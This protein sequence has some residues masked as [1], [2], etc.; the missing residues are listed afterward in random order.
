MPLPGLP[1]D[2]TRAGKELGS[3]TA[4]AVPANSGSA[5]RVDEADSTCV[6]LGLNLPVCAV[7]VG[8]VNCSSG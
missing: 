4:G 1:G 5:S 3:T 8:D 2:A 7:E 6:L